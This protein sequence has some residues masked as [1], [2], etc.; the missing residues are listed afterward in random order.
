MS[1]TTIS[2]AYLVT[3]VQTSESETVVSTPPVAVTV[4][5]AGV[6]PQGPPGPP[7]GG[8]YQHTQSTPASTWVVNHNLGFRPDVSVFSPGG[9]EVEAEI[10][11]VSTTQTEIR[12]SAAATGSARF[13]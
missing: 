2:P 3:E 13:I 11:H 9:I 12:F 4:V 5:E 1:S 6:G 10:A 8:S 7:G